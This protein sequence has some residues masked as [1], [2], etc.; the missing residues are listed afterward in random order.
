MT[1]ET[2]T[3]A[4]KAATTF[5]T[6]RKKGGNYAIGSAG[7]TALGN[8]TSTST[9]ADVLAICSTITRTGHVVGANSIGGATSTQN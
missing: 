7:V 9:V 3:A 4:T 5:S 6:E 8:L 1:A 2:F